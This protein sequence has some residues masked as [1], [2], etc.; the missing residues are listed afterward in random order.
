MQVR[1]QWA[2]LALGAALVLVLASGWAAFAQP[3]NW[4]GSLSAQG[5]GTITVGFAGSLTATG[6][7]AVSYYDGAGDAVVHVSGA[8]S[9]SVLASNNVQ[10]SGFNGTLTLTGSSLTMVASGNSISV[11]ASGSGQV[12]LDGTWSCTTNGQ[13]CGNA[14]S[15]TSAPTQTP[16]PTPDNGNGNGNGNGNSSNGNGNSSDANG[17]GN[18]SSSDGNGNS[19][20]ANG[21]GNTADCSSNGNGNSTDANGNGNSSSSN[22]NGNSANGNGNGSNGNGNSSSANGNGNSADCNGNGNDASGASGDTTISSDPDEAAVGGQLSA[23]DTVTVSLAAGGGSVVS[24]DQV[25]TVAV[26]NTGVPM[27]VVI[28]PVNRATD[29]PNPIPPTGLK[30]IH[31]VNLKLAPTGVP[32][33]VNLIVRYSDSEAAS[34][35]GGAGALQL[36]YWS[37]PLQRW[38]GLP[39]TLD[40]NAHTL[41]VTS[42]DVSAFFKLSRITL[43]GPG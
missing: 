14:A 5:N 42:I 13:S 10:Y 40:T 4:T 27:T 23:S 24:Q 11:N 32:S 41:T 7:G 3:A 21:N 20:D 39:S 22:G 18:S 30:A 15:L 9:K 37:V 19:T 29:T 43:L 16:V 12:T 35:T 8:G 17:N 28:D 26:A 33:A 25:E 1:R 36:Q 6:Q 34:V 31:D 38:V 2:L